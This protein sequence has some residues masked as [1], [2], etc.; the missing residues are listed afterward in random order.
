[1]AHSGTTDAATATA[2]SISQQLVTSAWNVVFATLA[3]IYVFGWTG[4]KQLV[5][6]AYTEAKE[7]STEMREE[8]K[9]KKQERKAGEAASGQEQ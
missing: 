2:Y 1:M 7:K 5:G 3:V 6:S 4:G 9:R 8:R